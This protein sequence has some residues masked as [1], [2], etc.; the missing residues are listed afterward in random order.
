[1]MPNFLL[2]RWHGYRSVWAS[3][4]MLVLVIVLSWFDWVVG[5]VALCAVAVFAAILVRSEL[6][7]RRELDEYIAG[8]SFVFGASKRKRLV[9]FLSVLFCMIT[10]FRLSGITAISRVYLH[11]RRS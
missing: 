5:L 9:R 11:V 8:L 2:N 10:S 7:F 4:L 1:M 6:A 3:L